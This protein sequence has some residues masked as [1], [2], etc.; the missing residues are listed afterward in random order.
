[1]N[2]TW[3]FN[4]FGLLFPCCVRFFGPVHV[5]LC[6]GEEKTC[7]SSLLEKTFQECRRHVACRRDINDDMLA[8]CPVSCQRRSLGRHVILRQMKLR[9]LSRSNRSCQLK[10]CF[11]KNLVLLSIH[12]LIVWFC[13]S[14]S[15]QQI[16]CSP[17][18]LNRGNNS[19]PA[20][21]SRNPSKMVLGFFKHAH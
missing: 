1:M 6:G 12:F 13:H 15:L 3:G 17:L 9:A 19:K 7:L 10:A 16:L 18:Y 8:T 20:K 2:K 21:K 11:Q 14:M 4:N 5:T